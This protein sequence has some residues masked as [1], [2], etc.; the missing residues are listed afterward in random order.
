MIFLYSKPIYFR[1]GRRFLP[2]IEPRHTPPPSLGCRRAGGT[3]GTAVRAGVKVY[4]RKPPPVDAVHEERSGWRMSALQKR[5]VAMKNRLSY[6]CGVLVLIGLFLYPARAVFA[7]PV[8]LKTSAEFPFTAGDEE[9]E[10]IFT[11]DNSCDIK[12]AVSSAPKIIEVEKSFG[13]IIL[14]PHAVGS[15]V[16]T[17]TGVDGSTA[18]LNVSADVPYFKHRLKERTRF[19]DESWYGTPKVEM[20]SEPGA[21]GTLTAGKDK[22]NVTFNKYGRARVKLKRVYK[23]DTVLKLKVKWNG[24]S[25]S[26]KSKL[27]SNTLLSEAK[28]TK[29]TIKLVT[30]NVHKGDVISLTYGGRTYTKKVKKSCDRKRKTYTFKPKK[31]VK[32]NSS[33]SYKIVN[34]Y[35]QVLAKDSVKLTKWKYTPPDDDEGYEPDNS[36][37]EE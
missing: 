13:Y 20:F 3:K 26:T 28:A 34:K 5:R 1:W 37:S 22:Y 31:A 2:K 6:V 21:K 30:W 14:K 16:I 25:A 29:K 18:T 32:K 12:E 10:W 23:I 7:D 33:F 27:F 4:V 11:T 35:K 9:S 19:T 24:A 15:A 17:V 36:T 8:E